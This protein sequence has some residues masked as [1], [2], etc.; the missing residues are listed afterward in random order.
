MAT[1]T[2]PIQRSFD[3]LGTPLFDTVFCVLDLETTGGSPAG[4]EITEVGAVKV[5]GGEILGTFHTLVNPRSPIPPFITVLTGI[6]QAMVVEAPTIDR[7]LPSFL[8]FCRGTVLVGHNLRFD[9]GFIETACR[10][11]GYP[12]P[13]N[14]RVDT[15]G[16]ARRLVRRDVRN[17]RLATLAAHF[18]SPIPPRHRALDDALATLHVFWGLLELAGGLGVTALEDLLLLPT[19]RGN[20]DYRK[21]ELARPLPRRPG[22]YLFRDRDGE[23]LYVGRAKNLRTRVMSYFHGDGRRRTA[24]LLRRLDRVDHR[25]CAGDLEAAV[26][27]LRLI[28]AHRPPFNRRSKPPKA[29]YW[30]T[31]TDERFPRVSLTRTR[32]DDALAA[33]GPFRG[34]RAAELVMHGIWDAVP[35]RR[36]TSRPGSREARCAAAQMG[37]ALCP[38]D[39]TLSELEY[40]RAVSALW[41]GITHEPEL[42]LSPLRAKMYDLASAQRFEQAAWVRDRYQALA[43]ALERRRR[44]I[45]LQEAGRIEFASVDGELAVVEGGRLLAS[46]REGDPRPLLPPTPPPSPSPTPPDLATAEEA[47]LIWRWISRPTVRVVRSFGPLVMPA[48]PVRLLRTG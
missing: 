7:V 33:L 22:V 25:V 3:E 21:A 36:C 32:R 12:I 11:L 24:D 39:G 20:P 1:G 16:L 27:E 43:R 19:A 17:L 23:V 26:T 46:W 2:A 4:S 47:E 9:L 31:I 29:S 44:W 28:W 6:T 35:V 37:S 10:R 34:R 38:C 18:R 30:V 40:R 14:R 5:R 42:L 15:L 13:P 48:R 41:E 45:A 8:E